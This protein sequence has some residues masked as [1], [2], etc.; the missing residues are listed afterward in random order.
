MKFTREFFGLWLET[1]F[2]GQP[3]FIKIDKLPKSDLHLA[4]GASVFRYL[5]ILERK[6]Q[7]AEGQK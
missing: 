7:A 2:F 4:H 6:Q 5:W 3:L 1:I